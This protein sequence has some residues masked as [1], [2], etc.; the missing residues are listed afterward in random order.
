VVERFVR[1]ETSHP[2]PPP[3]TQPQPTPPPPPPTPPSLPPT[4][5]HPLRSPA[6]PRASSSRGQRYAGRWLARRTTQHGLT[7]RI[8]HSARTSAGRRDGGLRERRLHATRVLRHA[9]STMHRART[10]SV[11]WLDE[12]ANKEPAG[13]LRE[14][15]AAHRG[16]RGDDRAIRIIRRIICGKLARADPGRLAALLPSR[17][18]TSGWPRLPRARWKRR[19]RQR[20]PG[21]MRC[22]FFAREAEAALPVA[23]VDIGGLWE[24]MG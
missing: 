14:I 7:A 3:P 11:A 2:P 15:A 10:G 9:P 1:L 18:R 22:G 6:P 8:A 4:P 20:L 21:P 13:K 24:V 12:I 5:A 19:A 23:L 16:R 17:I